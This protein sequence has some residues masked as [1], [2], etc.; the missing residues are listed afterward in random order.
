M[1]PIWPIAT[2][3]RAGERRAGTVLDRRLLGA[4]ARIA[5]AHA[6]RRRAGVARV[7]ALRRGRRAARTRAAR[8]A[9]ANRAALVGRF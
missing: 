2:R 9:A 3:V 5:R 1:G 6:K 4:A 7:A 8:S